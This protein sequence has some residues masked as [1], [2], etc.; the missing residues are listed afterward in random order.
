[1]HIANGTARKIRIFT[2][3]RNTKDWVLGAKKE[4]HMAYMWKELCKATKDKGMEI[5]IS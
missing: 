4:G 1:M 3:S 5:E 2:D